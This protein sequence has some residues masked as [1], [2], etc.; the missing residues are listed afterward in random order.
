MYGDTKEEE[1]KQQE[2]E[3][4]NRADGMETMDMPQVASETLN[5]AQI[6]SLMNVIQM[7]KN[8]QISRQEAISII[9][10]TLGINEE[11]AERFIENQEA[12]VE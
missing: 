1:W 3:R 5:G 7:E 10:S 8:N 12:T 9:T 11:T 4:L 2:I 6:T